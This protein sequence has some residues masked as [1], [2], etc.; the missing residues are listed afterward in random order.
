LIAA[1]R[2]HAG[3]LTDIGT[4]K[5]SIF[6]ALRIWVKAGLTALGAI[7]ALAAAA[8]G[9]DIAGFYGNWAN[10]GRDES[11][12]R[13]VIVSPAGGMRAMVR[14]YGDCHPNECDWG[15]VPAET[16][17]GAGPHGAPALVALIHYGF[18]H[19][20]ITLTPAAADGLSFSVEI[21][22]VAGTGRKDVVASGRLG[23]SDWAGPVS[24]ASWELPLDRNLGWGGGARGAAIPRPGQ[25]CE[26]FDPSSLRLTHAGPGWNVTAGGIFLLHTDWDEKT[27]QRA[28]AGLRH[29][30]FDAKCHT[31][32]VT[33]WKRGDAM[34]ADKPSF[35]ECVRFGSTT[36]HVVR[37]NNHWLVVDGTT[38]IHDLKESRDNALAV[39]AMI[40]FYRL[41]RKC[42]IGW[43]NPALIYWL[44]AEN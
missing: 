35:G 30:R 19:R 34:P 9:A 18:A 16:Q 21:R 13:H 15:V 41:E 38:T 27:A 37:S 7:F 1:R 28:L 33:F 4:V 36:A 23:R 29:Y 10:A 31:G 39:L 25:V 22:F 8:S 6:H 14:V 44:G 32:T 3:L 12:I 11:G 26:R 2:G 5:P 17:P 20:K 43:P 24:G 42:A 40:R